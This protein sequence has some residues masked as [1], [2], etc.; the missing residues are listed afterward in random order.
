MENP[1]EVGLEHALRLI[2]SSSLLEYIKHSKSKYVTPF[3]SVKENSFNHVLH[4]LSIAKPWLAL[5][6]DWSSMDLRALHSII[7]IRVDSTNPLACM[8]NFS[9]ILQLHRILVREAS[10][11]GNEGLQY[12][13]S[14]ISLFATTMFGYKLTQKSTWIWW[15]DIHNSTR[16]DNYDNSLISH[17]RMSKK[18]PVKGGI[19]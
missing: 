11:K 16:V 18:N 13:N 6:K 9:R 7:P 2:L 3:A 14:F 4:K 19:E 8:E 10:F 15:I 12:S 5:V 17:V 1:F